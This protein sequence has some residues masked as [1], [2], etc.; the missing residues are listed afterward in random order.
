MCLVLVLGLLL[1]SQFGSRNA[2]DS[3]TGEKVCGSSGVSSSKGS[4]CVVAGLPVKTVLLGRRCRWV[5]AL[6]LHLS[7][8]L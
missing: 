8:A 3:L 7:A 5:M 6:L 1:G 2:L 4:R